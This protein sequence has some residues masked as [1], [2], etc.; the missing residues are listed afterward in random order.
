M[1]TSMGKVYLN[2]GQSEKALPF[3]ESAVTIFREVKDRSG[4]GLALNNLGII[5]SRLGQSEK[6][7]ES[8]ELALKLARELKQRS[9]GRKPPHHVGNSVWGDGRD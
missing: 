1:L 6:A 5:Y 3:T 2:S 7:L 8:L 9:D 4:E